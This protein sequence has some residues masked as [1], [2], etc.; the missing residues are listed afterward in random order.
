VNRGPRLSVNRGLQVK[1]ALRVNRLWPCPEITSSLASASASINNCSSS[2]QHMVYAAANVLDKQCLMQAVVEHLEQTVDALERSAQ[3]TRQG[4]IH[5]E[6]RAENPKDTRGLE[7]SY[8]ARG[9]AQRVIEMRDAVARLRQLPLRS[10]AT[11]ETIGL[12]SVVQVGCDGKR[13]TYFLMPAAGGESVR[14][15]GV[16]VQTITPDSP[17]GRAL[18][19]KC[20]GDEFELLVGGRLREY[21]I[22]DV[23]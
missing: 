5:E 19:T 12:S 16:E 21:E 3:A 7:A 2:C 10:F 4:A 1:C 8:L 22:C 14:V 23:S 18:M 13:R 20:E 9:Q 6:S 11:G 17:V 15:D